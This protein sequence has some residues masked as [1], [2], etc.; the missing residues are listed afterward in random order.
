MPIKTKRFKF[1]LDFSSP[2]NSK[3]RQNTASESQY[4]VFT[5]PLI[6]KDDWSSF[7]PKHRRLWKKLGVGDRGWED[8]VGEG[9]RELSAGVNFWNRLLLLHSSICLCYCEIG[10]C[11]R[12][13]KPVNYRHDWEKCNNSSFV[14]VFS[15]SE[16]LEGVWRKIALNKE[17]CQNV[18]QQQQFQPRGAPHWQKKGKI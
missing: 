17:A 6:K 11:I 15:E 10:I 2:P 1:E 12:E 3:I 4:R 14:C 9:E 16:V 5:H 8:S 18:R 7:F 13:R